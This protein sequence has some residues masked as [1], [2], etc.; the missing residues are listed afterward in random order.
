MRVVIPMASNAHRTRSRGTNRRE[1]ERP[2]VGSNDVNQLLPWWS[3]LVH[4]MLLAADKA[5]RGG[6]EEDNDR[7]DRSVASGSAGVRIRAAVDSGAG[8][9]AR[10]VH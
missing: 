7:E 4:Q 6:N 8:V 1:A 3:K 5:A 10:R 2:T 9:R